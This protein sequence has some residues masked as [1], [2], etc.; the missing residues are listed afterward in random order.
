MIALPIV[1]IVGYS[2]GRV[3]RDHWQTCPAWEVSDSCCASDK[4][5]HIDLRRPNRQNLINMLAN[6]RGS[7]VDLSDINGSTQ[8][9][10]LHPHNCTGVANRAIGWLKAG[11]AFFVNKE[12]NYLYLT[13]HRPVTHEQVYQ[14]ELSL[15]DPLSLYTVYH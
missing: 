1:A 8:T 7:L 10:C 12:C 4:T 15:I 3:L 6:V 9:Y 11:G 14:L 5:R 13:F 2:F